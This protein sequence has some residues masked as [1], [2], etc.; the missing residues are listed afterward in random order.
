MPFCSELLQFF[1]SSHDDCYGVSF[2]EPA[3]QKNWRIIFHENIDE[4]VKI[5]D[6]KKLIPEPSEISSTP[7]L[8][9]VPLEFVQSLSYIKTDDYR[10]NAL[11]QSA[12]KEI[13]QEDTE[14]D[15]YDLLGDEKENRYASEI[16][17]M[18]SENKNY[19]LGYPSF[20]QYDV[21]EYMDEKEASYYDT[22]LLHLDSL[23]CDDIMCWGDAGCAN[24]LINSEA[25]QNR[26]FSKVYYTW[27]CT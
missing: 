14:K 5:E 24:F 10:M 15:L 25:L 19:I 9:S 23:C 27:D 12:V 6:V 16:Y 22:T 3:V 17:N 11:V 4:S 20:I 1:I 7:I 21:R 13:I 26:D 8:N 2:D 18:L